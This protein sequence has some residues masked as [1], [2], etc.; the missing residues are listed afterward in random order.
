MVRPEVVQMLSKQALAAMD[1]NGIDDLTAAEVISA[2]YSM[3][4]HVTEVLFKNSSDA[5]MQHNIDQVTAAIAMLWALVPQQKV[6]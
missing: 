3:T 6:H 5:N 1:G 2:C 4:R